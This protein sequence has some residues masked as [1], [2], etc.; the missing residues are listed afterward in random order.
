MTTQ[1]HHSRDTPE[2]LREGDS[3]GDVDGEGEAEAAER[4][5]YT[6]K[7]YFLCTKKIINCSTGL[8]KILL[9]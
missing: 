4:K 3:L 6:I 9:C 1:T 5:Y 2:G 8:S 7:K